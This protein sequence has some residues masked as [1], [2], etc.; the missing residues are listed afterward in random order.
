VY[1]YYVY[2][3]YVYLSCVHHCDEIIYALLNP[4]EMLT[5][6]EQSK[7][8]VTKKGYLFKYEETMMGKKWKKYYFSIKSNFLAWYHDRSAE[9]PLGIIDLEDGKLEASKSKKPKYEGCEFKISVPSGSGSRVLQLRVDYAKDRGPWMEA[10]AMAKSRHIAAGT[11]NLDR[12]MKYF[13]VPSLFLVCLIVSLLTYALN[14]FS[15][16]V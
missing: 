5:V 14:R 4:Q 3:Y 16:I 8:Q 10:M 9:K 2:L 11:I 15:S 6:M 13:I 7:A 1:L 12:C